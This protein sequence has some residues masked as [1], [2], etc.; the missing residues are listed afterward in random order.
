AE[1][2]FELNVEGDGDDGRYYFK[3]K[4]LREKQKARQ[5][6]RQVDKT[7]EWA[8]NNYYKLLIEQQN[9]DL[10]SASAFWR[11]YAKA[12]PAKPF[13]SQ[14]LAE[15]SRNFTEAMFSLAV[16]DLTFE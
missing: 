10:V 8:E 16:L 14:H 4:K 3:G 1:E 5:L 12:D 13:Y 6:F 9:A 15:A 7:Q 11:D 2:S